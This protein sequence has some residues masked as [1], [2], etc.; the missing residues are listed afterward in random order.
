M[1]SCT[2]L[3]VSDTERT[4]IPHVVEPV[5]LTGKNTFKISFMAKLAGRY[6]INIKINGLSINGGDIH[7]RFIPGS[8][9]QLKLS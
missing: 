3:A 8:R 6:I 1:L 9:H 4:S 7:R 5:G 2:I